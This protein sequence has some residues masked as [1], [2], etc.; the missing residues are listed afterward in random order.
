M[1]AVLPLPEKP[2]GS[3]IFACFLKKMGLKQS[4]RLSV[5]P[6]D[7][8]CNKSWV[9]WLILTT[10]DRRMGVWKMS[11][12]HANQHV[13]CGGETTTVTPAWEEM[14]MRAQQPWGFGP[15]N[16]QQT[17]EPAM[18]LSTPCPQER[19]G[20]GEAIRTHGGHLWLARCCR[21]L[22]T[23]HRNQAVQLVPSFKLIYRRKILVEGHSN[24]DEVCKK[25]LSR[26]QYFNVW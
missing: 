17:S 2:G 9:C 5:C 4:C 21:T 10:S 20:T 13:G 12:C 3:Y 26:S 1:E 22:D 8:P 6:L 18:A 24:R 14:A 19:L 16:V 7:V 25:V 23:Y 15:V 11:E